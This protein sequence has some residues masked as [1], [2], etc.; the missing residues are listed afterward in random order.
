MLQTLILVRHGETDHQSSVRFYGATDVPL[1]A[2]GREQMRDA[3]RSLPVDRVDRVVA[4]PLQRSW[5]A[6]ATVAPG[7]AVHLESGFREI[8]FGRWEG[9]TAEEIEAAEPAL[10][11]DWQSRLEG[12]EFPEGERRAAFRERVLAGLDRLLESEARS[13]LVVAHKGVIRTIVEKL[14]GEAPEQ[15]H[16]ELGE[17]IQVTRGADGAWF[18]GPRSSDPVALRS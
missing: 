2:E 7:A 3:A 4:S 18:R 14:C 11:R 6:A 15:P 13:C 9:L 16:P 5:A 10:Y 12:F 8:D 17:V 1:S